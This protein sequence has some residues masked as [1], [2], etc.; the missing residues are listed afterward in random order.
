MDV[1]ECL[2]EVVGPH[3]LSISN[4]MVFLTKD[5]INHV[6]KCPGELKFV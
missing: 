6:Y 5:V 1:C 3:Q 4:E 2:C